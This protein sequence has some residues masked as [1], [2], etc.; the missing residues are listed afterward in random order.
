MALQPGTQMMTQLEKHR[1]EGV[2]RRGYEKKRM[3]TGMHQHFSRCGKC[4]DAH[5]IETY[6][7]EGL[8]PSP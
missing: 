1:R 8:L 3:E 4:S 7:S 5:T 6:K 2:E